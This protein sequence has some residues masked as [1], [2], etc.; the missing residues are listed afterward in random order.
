[1]QKVFKGFKSD[2]YK[3]P[4]LHDQRLKRTRH[5]FRISS[6]LLLMSALKQ[7]LDAKQKRITDAAM[8]YT[9]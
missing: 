3:S 2:T 5:D 4:H 7:S 8:I 9:E 6:L 1:M